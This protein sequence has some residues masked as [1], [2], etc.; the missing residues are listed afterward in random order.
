M[1]TTENMKFIAQ[2]CAV[3]MV[4]GSIFTVSYQLAHPAPTGKVAFDQ[5]DYEFSIADN[6]C[7]P[8]EYVIQSRG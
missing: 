6:K 8:F 2:V 7:T 4:L 5:R 1:F 3:I